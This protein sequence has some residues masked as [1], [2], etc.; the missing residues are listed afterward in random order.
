MVAYKKLSKEERSILCK[1]MSKNYYENSEV[2]K[3]L[4]E[5]NK[6]WE[7]EVNRDIPSELYG[8]QEKYPKAIA[9]TTCTIN[10]RYLSGNKRNSWFPWPDLKCSNVIYGFRYTSKIWAT[11][12]DYM[13]VLTEYNSKLYNKII[14]DILPALNDID[15]FANDLE[16]ALNS[17]S[18]VNSLKNEMPEAYKIYVDTY[19]EPTSYCSSKNSTSKKCDNIEKV[20]A[21]YNSTKINK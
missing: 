4:E 11:T 19:G 7:D 5:T 6:E 1:R 18:T 8:I 14:N 17:I 15:K 9:T 3:L 10:L 21:I 20:R 16:C 13:N 12:T 2:K